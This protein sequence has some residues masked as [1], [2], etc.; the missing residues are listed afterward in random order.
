MNIRDVKKVCNNFLT[1]FYNLKKEEY[2]SRGHIVEHTMFHSTEECNVD[3]IIL[4][5]LDWRRVKRGKFG[6]GVSFSS[7]AD[8]ANC[9]SNRNNGE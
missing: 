2:Q 4:N 6:I 3:S 9:H 7:D 5:N 8:Y 1:G